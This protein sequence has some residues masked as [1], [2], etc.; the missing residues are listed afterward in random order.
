[1]K[2]TEQVVH[3]ITVLYPLML[4]GWPLKVHDNGLV[5]LRFKLKNVTKISTVDTGLLE[6]DQNGLNIADEGMLR[7]WLEKTINKI[8]YSLTYTEHTHRWRSQDGTKICS[9]ASI[10]RDTKLQG[11]DLFRRTRRNMLEAMLASCLA[12]AETEEGKL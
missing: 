4:A 12:L 5:E 3:P 9:M 7:W 11:R 2:A 6:Y 1:M 10:D 8:G